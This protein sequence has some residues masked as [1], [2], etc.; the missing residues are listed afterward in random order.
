MEEIRSLRTRTEPSFVT[1]REDIRAG[2]EETR[3]YM[4]VLYED[5]VE[6]IATIGP[7][8]RRRPRR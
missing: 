6:R 2:D 7:A 1:P 5:L 3:R 8:G 4:R